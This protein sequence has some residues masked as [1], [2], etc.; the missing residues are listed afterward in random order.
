MPV[1]KMLFLTEADARLVDEGT[2]PAANALHQ[3]HTN[4]EETY[5]MCQ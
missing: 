5:G 2:L 1:E 4:A 3:C